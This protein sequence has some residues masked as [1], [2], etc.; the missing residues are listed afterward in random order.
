[1]RDVGFPE[2][3]PRRAQLALPPVRACARCPLLAWCAALAARGPSAIYLSRPCAAAARNV[4]TVTLR[5]P[6]PCA[7]HSRIF[8]PLRMGP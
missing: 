8:A 1:M 2:R 5:H 3:S 4:P 6:W 7:S